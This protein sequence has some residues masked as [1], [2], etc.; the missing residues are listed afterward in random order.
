MTFIA[1]PLSTKPDTVA[2]AEPT[3]SVIGK[4]G[5]RLKAPAA[6]SISTNG[7]CSAGSLTKRPF[8]LE[9]P[10]HRCCGVESV[11]RRPYRVLGAG[12]DHRQA[13]FPCQ[14]ACQELQQAELV[15]VRQ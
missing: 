4:Y 12:L 11:V 10:G 13:I 3:L 7:Y 14:F 15:R 5:M 8:L 9:N 2:D 6:G 1:A